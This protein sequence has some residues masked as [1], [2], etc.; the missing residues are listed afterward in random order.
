MRKQLVR[1]P[2]EETL[3]FQGQSGAADDAGDA[4]SPGRS[5]AIAPCPKFQNLIL[6]PDF[7]E[8]L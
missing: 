5:P 1:V 3:S 8:P 7:F 2:S 6:S 4:S